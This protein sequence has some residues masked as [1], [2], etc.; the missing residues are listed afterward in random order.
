MTKTTS[1]RLPKLQ[2][3]TGKMKDKKV[4]RK[5]YAKSVNA[6][7]LARDHF[8]TILTMFHPGYNPSIFLN[9]IL[10]EFISFWLYTESKILS[11]WP[12]LS[13]VHNDLVWSHEMSSDSSR[14]KS[15]EF[16]FQYGVTS[17]IFKVNRNCTSRPQLIIIIFAKSIYLVF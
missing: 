10:V 9:F 7:I 5:M 13:L 14:V 16:Y 1:F 15:L 4:M 8:L 11:F 12:C 6:C 3:S 2:S 17:K